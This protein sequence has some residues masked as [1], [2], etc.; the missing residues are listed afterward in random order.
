MQTKFETDRSATHM[1]LLENQLKLK[2]QDIS[3]C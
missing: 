1:M 2:D 3:D